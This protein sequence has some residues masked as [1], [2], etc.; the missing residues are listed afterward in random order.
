MPSLV[1]KTL[2]QYH[3]LEEIGR[4]GMAI[5]YRAYQPSLQRYV[6]IKVLP[7]QFTF[8]TTFV[9]R[10]LQEARAAA[11]LKHPNIVTIH[12]VGEQDGVHYIVM[13]YLEGLPLNELLRR[14]GALPLERVTRIV[15]QI[16]SALDYAHAQGFVH[17]DIK[18][19]NIIVGRNDHA[20]LTDFGT[21]KAAAGTTLTK[22]GMLIGTP[23]YM[24]PEQVRG[25][26]VDHRADIYALGV[27]CY[28]MLTGQVPF[29]GETPAVLHAHVYEPL[30]P[31]RSLNRQLPAAVEKAVNRALVKEPE[32]RYQSAGELAGALEAATRG[33]RVTPR[34]RPVALPIKA[35]E[36]PTQVARP[37]VIPK[38]GVKKRQPLFLYLGLAV[39]V[40]A[41]AIGVGLYALGTGGGAKVKPTL[42]PPTTTLRKIS[43]LTPGL[44]ATPIPPTATL[45]LPTSVPISTPPTQLPSVIMSVSPT[46]SATS[47]PTSTSTPTPIS[48][49]TATRTPT[50][51]P[52]ATPFAIVRV[53]TLNVRQ[54]PG[55]VYD[56]IGRVTSS[57]SLATLGRTAD[58]GWLQVCCV[59]GKR[60]WVASDLVVSSVSLQALPV[61]TRIPPTPTPRLPALLVDLYHGFGWGGAGKW[62]EELEKDGYV[63]HTNHSPLSLS[64]LKEYDVLLVDLA[65]YFD[66]KQP[67]REAE[68]AAIKE[69]V[70]QGGGLFLTGLGWVWTS[71]CK[72]PIDKYPLNILAREYGV[73][74]KDDYLS[75]A[76]N[77]VILPGNPDSV[78][79]VFYKPFMADHP[80][81]TGV[82]R[83]ACFGIPGSLRV[84]APAFPLI[85]GDD[86]AQDFEGIQNPKTMA[87]VA[88]ESGGRI[89]FMQH[90][91]YFVDDD[92]D[93]NGI[94]NVYEYDNLK[95]LKN[96]IKWLVKRS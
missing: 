8:D 30:P 70:A 47:T 37:G 7:P 48:T 79:P 6:A 43:Q 60:G 12:D 35:V 73:W 59:E 88:L 27:V 86:D 26:R 46:P 33:K 23:A 61:I 9:Q 55:T 36:P 10:F 15:A 63:I 94:P 42:P 58:G 22:T 32:R 84:D 13:E 69:Y 68:F 29:G 24:S 57:Q 31:L 14:E 5:V 51:T 34:P 4:G 56:I 28:E 21:V 16:A 77:R 74:F 66:Q 90:G 54:G 91:G 45:V 95:L 89:V 53:T 72:Q 52:T 2:G 3:V 18:P 49:P 11:R 44:G 40:L 39:A 64:M 67:F 75:D 71:Y 38:P 20:T 62:K 25:R 76:T 82:N 96:V 81:T 19:S 92:S 87:A 93:G 65:C 50:V 83:I 85:W 80:I 17:R 41:L 78:S 1:G